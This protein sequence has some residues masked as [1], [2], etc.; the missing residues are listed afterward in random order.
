MAE[1][2][3]DACTGRVHQCAGAH[4]LWMGKVLAFMDE[5]IGRALTSGKVML[6]SDDPSAPMVQVDKA[7]SPMSG[8]EL[9]ARQRAFAITHYEIARALLNGVPA[10]GC[11]RF[12]PSEEF[13]EGHVVQYPAGRSACTDPFVLFAAEQVVN[14]HKQYFPEN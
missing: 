11:V 10:G 13:P 6:P 9:D 3:C 1:Q 5:I 4:E 8:P 12:P 2:I 14:W 7:V